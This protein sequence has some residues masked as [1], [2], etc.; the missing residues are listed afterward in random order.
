MAASPYPLGLGVSLTSS[1]SRSRRKSLPLYYV[2]ERVA[3]E[4]SPCSHQRNPSGVLPG[5]YLVAQP[6]MEFEVVMTKVNAV[7]PGKGSGGNQFSAALYVDGV[8]THQKAS[9]YAPKPV[10]IQFR[11]EGFVTER[12]RDRHGNREKHV[13]RFTFRESLQTPDHHHQPC[14]THIGS[15]V[16]DF[17]VE[18]RRSPDDYHE[19]HH[20]S[21]P[22]DHVVSE[23]DAVKFG[24]SLVVSAH[25][26]TQ[27]LTSRPSRYIPTDP[28]PVPDAAIRIFVREEA[29]MKSRRL[30][31]PAGNPCTYDMF[32]RL[33]EPHHHTLHYHNHNTTTQTAQR[34]QTHGES[35]DRHP[36]HTPL[37]T[38]R[39]SRAHATRNMREWLLSA[40][41]RPFR[42]SDHQSEGGRARGTRPEG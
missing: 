11:A 10:G 4:R 5:W 27:V 33:L 41:Q 7:M 21:Y 42:Q 22:R 38:Q 23:I 9:F 30:I 18:T 40:T 3:I 15:I 14:N 17:V 25:G 28:T 2:S 16:A 13:N 39:N 20:Y 1:S 26:P 34:H 36:A 8:Y 37:T 24:K 19:H 31:D 6:N 35:P 29:W 32:I 12:R